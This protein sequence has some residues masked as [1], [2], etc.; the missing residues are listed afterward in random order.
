MLRLKLIILISLTLFL[1][2]ILPYSVLARNT[3]SFDHA[4]PEA[5]NE[6]HSEGHLDLEELP[7]HIEPEENE[8]EELNDLE[9]EVT[10]THT[11][12]AYT[13]LKTPTRA[14]FVLKIGGIYRGTTPGPDL[15]EASYAQAKEQ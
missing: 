15:F 6:H 2:F 9:E 12:H 14:V 11:N 7:H 3:S 5:E 13:I 1:H 4:P 10:L 8:L